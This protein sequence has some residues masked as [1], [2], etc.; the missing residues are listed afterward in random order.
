M[1]GRRRVNRLVPVS[2]GGAVILFAVILG[3]SS[4]LAD[5]APA[6]FPGRDGAIAFA[7]SYDLYL[8]TPGGR[9]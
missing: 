1:T 7:R 3:L 9:V 6:A 4:S 5:G 8:M 2:P